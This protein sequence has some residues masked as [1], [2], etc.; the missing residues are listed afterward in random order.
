M[1]IILLD[2][3][4]FGLLWSSAWGGVQGEHEMAESRGGPG[5]DMGLG[6]AGRAGATWRGVAQR[7][8]AAPALGGD[9]GNERWARWVGCELG[10]G[11]QQA[12]AYNDPG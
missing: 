9:G 7:V 5:V 2:L 11:W 1:G 8:M 6:S 10:H 12:R 4:L 3:I